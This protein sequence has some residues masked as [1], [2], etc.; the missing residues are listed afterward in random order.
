MFH[1]A[2][3]DH[4]SESS[5]MSRKCPLCGAEFPSGEECRDHFDL[6]LALEYENPV[7]WGA[8]HHL[9]VLCYMLQHN[10]YSSDVWL[11]AR[12]MVVQFIQQGCSPADMLKQNRQIFNS[13]KR[14][15]S[16]TKDAKLAEFETITW[17]CTI[18]AIRCDDPEIYCADVWHWA[19]CVLAD[20][21]S[22]V[23]KQKPVSK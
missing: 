19:V 6:C 1:P 14:K 7:A 16:V 17:S 20:T 5:E 3:K 4:I 23:Q 2:G 12:K 22:I 15:W 18:A 10:A 21:E 9:T 13:G 8:V 11:D